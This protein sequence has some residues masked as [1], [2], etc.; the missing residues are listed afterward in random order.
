LRVPTL[1]DWCLRYLELRSSELS[2][3][4]EKLHCRA[5]KLL[6]SHF[7]SNRLIDTISRADAADWRHELSQQFLDST[8]CKWVRCAKVIFSHALG[9]DYIDKNAFDKLRGTARKTETKLLDLSEKQL[10][11]TITHSGKHRV[12]IALC[13][14]AGLRK[15]EAYNLT[16]DDIVWDKNKLIVQNHGAVTSKAR[17]REVRIEPQ[18]MTILLDAFEN[19]KVDRVVGL[20]A[21]NSKVCHALR[22]VTRSL[23]HDGDGLTMQGLRRCRDTIW[24]QQFPAFVCSAWLGHTEQVAMKHYL[25]VPDELY[26]SS[27][28]TPSDDTNSLAKALDTIKRLRQLLKL[29]NKETI[30]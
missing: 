26:N 9:H 14:Y 6:L 5:C 2:E 13:W 8:V 16:W 15:M 22:R 17:R 1:G 19:S 30:L 21:K 27:P 12:W 11:E 24:H 3:A 23:G 29:Q 10:S 25:S 28:K 20:V 18:L 7:G 4:T